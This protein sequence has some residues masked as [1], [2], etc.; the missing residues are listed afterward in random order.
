MFMLQKN[1]QSKRVRIRETMA[2]AH[3]LIKMNGEYAYITK[4]IDREITEIQ[5]CI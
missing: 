1:D 4:R 5:I 2:V 3:A